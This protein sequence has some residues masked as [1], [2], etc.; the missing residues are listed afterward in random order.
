MT[1]PQRF[2]RGL[3]VHQVTRT[4]T[5]CRVGK[6][7]RCLSHV[8]FATFCFPNAFEKRKRP[9][10]ILTQ[11]SPNS[12][13]ST[14]IWAFLSLLIVLVSLSES[15]NATSKKQTLQA[16]AGPLHS[17]A[18]G[19]HQP[20]RPNVQSSLFEGMGTH[21]PR[22]QWVSPKHPGIG[23]NSSQVISQPSNMGFVHWVIKRWGKKA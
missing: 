23:T 4:P 14:E 5:S 12:A 20:T 8:I 22:Q 11:L 21:V 6:D 13:F 1:Q 17:A 10:P 9:V 16:E 19:T 3:Q 2:T 7:R 15:Q 18:G